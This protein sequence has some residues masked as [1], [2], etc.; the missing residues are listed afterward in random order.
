VLY[1]FDMKYC[2]IATKG[3]TADS[4]N[5]FYRM[6]NVLEH[7]KFLKMIVYMISIWWWV[8][9]CSQALSVDVFNLS[10]VTQT[11]LNLMMNGAN[12]RL[13]LW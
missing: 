1:L 4:T 2:F 3:N 7:A 5:A 10:L 11:R 8:Y 9:I 12:I 6:H 13:L